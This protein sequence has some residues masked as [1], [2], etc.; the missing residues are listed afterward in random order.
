MAILEEPIKELQVVKNF[1]DGEWVE[2]K[3]EVRDVINPATCKTIGKEP[4]SSTND[5]MMG[6]HS[7]DIASGIDEFVIRQPLGVFGIINPLNFPFMIPLWLVPYAIATGN[8]ITFYKG[9]YDEP[10]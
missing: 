6:Y 8:C 4:I 10:N 5:L 2:S 3:G 1:I 7:E 9:G